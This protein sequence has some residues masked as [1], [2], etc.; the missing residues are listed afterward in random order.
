MKK[1]AILALYCSH[2]CANDLTWSTP[3]VLSTV[4][5]NAADPRIGMD[6]HGNLVAAWIE[7]DVV[8]SN[9]QLYQGSWNNFPTQVSDVGATSLE[10]IVDKA[11]NATAIW[12]QYGVI[13][14]STLPFSGNWS[15]P[16]GL[17]PNAGDTPP[18]EVAASPQISAHSAGHLAAIWEFDGAIQ[19]SIK[20]SNQDW[21]T[22]ASLS[23]PC[24]ACDSPQIAIGDDETMVAV[25]HSTW[26]GVDVI[27][28]SSTKIGEPWPKYPTLISD[29]DIPSIHPKVAINSKGNPIAAW[30]RYDLS[31]SN[32]SNVRVQTT[33]GHS[34]GTWDAPM[35]LSA[36]GMK[37]PDSLSLEVAFNP[38]DMAFVL[39]TNSYDGSTFNLEGSVH[40]IK[41]WIPTIHIVRSNTNLYDHNLVISPSGYAYAVY[42]ASE[43]SYA[44]PVIR[45]FKANTYNMEPNYGDIATISNSGANSYPRI[46]GTSVDLAQAASAIWLNYDGMQTVVQA[47]VA[48]GSGLP[49]PTALSVTQSSNDYGTITEFYNT[50]TW[51]SASPDSSS[52]W[53]I[54]RNGEWLK[55]LPI[56]MLRFIDHNTVENQPVTYGIALQ[57]KDGD[58]S[59]IS[60]IS[61]P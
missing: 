37:N 57:S 35:D 49:A 43:P 51:T 18:G 32:Y 33:F 14:S 50:V 7:N 4:G 61:F 30:Y 41:E 55:T 13:Q 29:K 53:I 36:P 21:S 59:P 34:N 38:R 24:P 9:R 25:W 11:G 39:W 19:V 31:G 15:Y 27:Y 22:P 48:Y 10:L 20:Q 54:F 5:E 17:S 60:E 42:M 28:S 44:S 40:T 46:D 12:N 3:Q 26:N 6:P 23:Y 52:N 58:M 45:A 16:Q 1:I 2:L 8:M 56:S 47:S